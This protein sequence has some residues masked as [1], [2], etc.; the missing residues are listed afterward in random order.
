[1]SRAF[2]LALCAL[3]AACEVAAPPTPRAPGGGP[4]GGPGT[5]PGGSAVPVD[6]GAT[7]AAPDA[8]GYGLDDPT[9]NDH[10]G[11]APRRLALELFRASLEQVVGARWVGPRTVRTAASPTGTRF[12][13][14]ADLIDFYGRTLG[15]PDYVTT[16]AEVTE[17]TITFTK[18][19]ADAARDVCTAGVRADV[20]RAPAERRLLVE[21][22]EAD[23]LPAAEAA[24]RRNLAALALR[25]WGVVLAPDGAA[26]TA[27]LGVFRAAASPP[28]ATP[29]DGW[30]AVCIDLATD[31]RFMSY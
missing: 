4:G 3:L 15:R 26:V 28:M 31:P 18:L 2:C 23:A 27:M 1:M 25:F 14:E 12:E 11:R 9:L 5:G 7:P 30:R 29:L 17:P 22:T 13:A 24:V 16:T 8:S 10:V 21:A 6:P 20:A 19:A